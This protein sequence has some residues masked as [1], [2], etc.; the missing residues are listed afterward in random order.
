MQACVIGEEAKAQSP[1]ANNWQCQDLN[2]GP[3]GPRV[4]L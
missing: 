1:T 3:F 4:R 2:L